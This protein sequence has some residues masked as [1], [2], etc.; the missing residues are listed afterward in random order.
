MNPH[1]KR[2]LRHAVAIALIASAGTMSLVAAT[3]DVSVRL[4]SVGYLPEVPKIA[5]VCGASATNTFSVIDATS[6]EVVFTGNLS[7]AFESPQTHERVRKADFSKLHWSGNYVVH[8]PGLP[9]SAPFTI[10]SNALNR[11]LECVMLGFYGQRCGQAVSFHWNG[12]TFTHAKCHAEDGWLDYNAP[13]KAGQRKDGTGGWHDAGDYG[14]YSLNAAFTCGMMLIAW[15]QRSDALKKLQLPAIPEHGGPLPDYLAEIKYELD[16]LLKMQMAT[17]Q[18]AHKLTTLEFGP[19]ELMPAADS[20]KRYFTPNSR[21]AT[22][23]FAAV[24]CMA[25]RVF[26]PYD[27]AYAD[28]WEA[29]AK[30]AWAAAR[31]MPDA[32]PDTSA[33]HTGDY[34]APMKNDYKWALIEVRLAF[35]ENFLTKEEQAR[36]AKAINSD[37]MFSVVWDWG[38][39]YNLGLYSWLFSLEAQKYPEAL[40]NLKRD[41]QR[42]ADEVVQTSNQHAYGRG[43]VMNYWGINGALARTVMNLYAA[44]KISG[45]RRYLDTA[46]AQ[47][48]YLYGRNPFGRSFVTGDGFRPPM[49]PHHRPSVTDGIADPWPGHLIGGP[50]ST[51]TGWLDEM[52]S[53]RTNEVAINWDAALIYALAVFYQE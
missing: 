8:I 51:E 3:N 25:A 5:T 44:F 18:V 10:S 49:F 4:C 42:A 24:G 2:S 38:N 34:F 14:K 30:K 37:H 11:S 9:D 15:Q 41:L 1:H 13:A 50:D 28:T 29:A 23:D 12:Q 17:G 26:G 36:F 52:V 40:A 39:G 35:G 16:W 43:L 19:M 47:V 46:Y 33:F 48:A 21:I 22:L 6:R 32:N 31:T 27:A 53:Y 7:P 45:D 20:E